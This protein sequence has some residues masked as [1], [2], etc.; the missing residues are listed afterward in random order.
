MSTSDNRDLLRGTL[1]N[2]EAMQM[3]TQIKGFPVNTD[4]H[5]HQTRIEDVYPNYD[6]IANA[7]GKLM[8]SARQP[9]SKQQSFMLAKMVKNMKDN[10]DTAFSKDTLLNGS[11]PERGFNLLEIVDQARSITELQIQ[12]HTSKANMPTQTVS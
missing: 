4:K 2:I 6:L 5:G 12:L 3:H 10:P 9:A 8:Y 1:A 7:S 11:L